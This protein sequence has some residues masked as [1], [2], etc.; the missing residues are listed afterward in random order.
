M[1][2]VR[3][4]AAWAFD[5]P[6]LVAG[7]QIEVV[8]VDP[9]GTEHPLTSRYA[10]ITTRTHPGVEAPL[11]WSLSRASIEDLRLQLQTA[12]N[13]AELTEVFRWFNGTLEC[14]TG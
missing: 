9:D 2:D 4:E 13:T 10:R 12:E 1:N 3:A 11:G 5:S 8:A 14:R 7:S 6:L